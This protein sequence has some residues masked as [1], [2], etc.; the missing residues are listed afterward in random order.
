MNSLLWKVGNQRPE[1][2]LKKVIYKI[3]QTKNIYFLLGQSPELV[4]S[5]KE[6]DYFGE[7]ALISNCNRQASV[8]AK[9]R[10]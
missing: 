1:N 3:K 2:H 9:V 5:Y 4:Y 7:L 8:L 6:G 10:I